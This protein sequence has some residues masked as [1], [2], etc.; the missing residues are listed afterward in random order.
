MEKKDVQEKQTLTSPT[1][2]GQI[3]F[4][5]KMLHLADDN[6]STTSTESDDEESQH[7][8]SPTVITTENVDDIDDQMDEKTSSDKSVEKN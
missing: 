6:D 5:G 1:P 3:Y 4:G 7:M 2:Q 8:D